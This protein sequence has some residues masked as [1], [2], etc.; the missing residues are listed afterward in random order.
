MGRPFRLQVR[1]CL[2]RLHSEAAQGTFDYLLATGIFV[3]A[4]VSGLFAFDAVIV[5]IVGH[6]CPS[7]DTADPLAAVGS[8]LSP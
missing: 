6:I 8:C 3:V 1:T 5:D 2:D 4:L 7:V